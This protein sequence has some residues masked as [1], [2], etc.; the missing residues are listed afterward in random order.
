MYL[1]VI[2]LL[3]LIIYFI[4]FVAQFYNVFFKGYAPFISTDK[5]TINKILSEVQIP[6]GALIYELGCGRARFL[7]IAEKKLPESK[8]IGIEN[9]FSLYFINAIKLKLQ[10]SKI[11]LL[12]DDFLEVNLKDADLIYCYLNNATMEKL[13]EKF[14]QE[15]KQGTQ[16][17][18][19]S[20]PI[21]QFAQKKVIIIKNKKIYFYQI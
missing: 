13:G 9:L 5:E 19:R 6:N 7:R 2:I 4:F 11:K 18:S 8:F 3:V 17:I 12:K 10:F 15:C 20:F 16:I 14:K 1:L 21:P